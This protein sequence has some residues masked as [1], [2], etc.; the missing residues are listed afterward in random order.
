MWIPED[1]WLSTWERDW[2]QSLWC[3]Q[4]W[5]WASIGDGLDPAF[6]CID[7][8]ALLSCSF[9]GA[10]RTWLFQV[11][12]YC[13]ASGKQ[14]WVRT[15]ADT[16]HS[17]RLHFWLILINCSLIHHFFHLSE[18]RPSWLMLL[19]FL[20]RCQEEANL[21]QCTWGSESWWCRTAC[22]NGKTR[23]LYRW[24]GFSP[25]VHTAALCCTLWKLGGKIIEW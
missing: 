11:F 19:L 1:Q 15:P 17:H 13:F 5:K 8:V 16:L 18:M 6:A 23:S 2:W 20:T 14:K 10:G 21:H 22:I 25:Q 4:L 12:E 24:G 7:G 9:S 3:P